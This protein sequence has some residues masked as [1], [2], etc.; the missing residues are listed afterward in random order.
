M[1]IVCNCG[2][3]MEFEID[4]TVEDPNEETNASHDWKLIEVNAEHDEAW[5]TCK[6]CSKSI[7]F[8]A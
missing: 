5:I 2:Q 4:E 6:K 7:H 3:E 8:F 1:K